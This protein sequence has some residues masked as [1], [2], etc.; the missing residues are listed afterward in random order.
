MHTTPQIFGRARIF[1]TGDPPEF[2][3]WSHEFEDYHSTGRL[4]SS[5]WCSEH[6]EMCY[7]EADLR[8]LFS[9][10]ATGSFQVLFKGKLW[11]ERTNSMDGEYYDEGFD[12]DE[13]INQVIEMEDES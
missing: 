5:Q 1:D 2:E 4:S 6:F 9:L 10:P 11:S 13:A 8:E 12:V 7:S 3:F